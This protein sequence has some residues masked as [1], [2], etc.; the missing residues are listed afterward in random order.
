MSFYRK[1][2]DDTL[3]VESLS[4]SLVVTR[5]RYMKNGGVELFFEGG[6]LKLADTSCKKGDILSPS[7]LLS[8]GELSA[9]YTSMTKAANCLAARSYTKKGLERRLVGSGVLKENAAEASEYFEQRGYIDDE[10]YALR[11]AEVMHSRKNYGRRKIISEL[12]RQGVP[13]DMARLVV[14][15]LPPDSEAATR[16][17]MAKRLDI[18][19]QSGRDKM[20]RHLA[21]RGFGAEDIKK[22][23]QDSSWE[24]EDEFYY[25]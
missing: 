14:D 6:S 18:S 19:E 20:F 25:E 11:K 4:H 5:V 13:Q 10:G 1:K 16:A 12:I 21:S 8:L 3:D 2:K 15:S 17:F 24:F 7:E 9:K 23:M 22:A